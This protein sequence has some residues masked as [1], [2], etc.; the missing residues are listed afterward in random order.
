[1]GLATNETSIYSVDPRAAD[2]F[3]LP[4]TGTGDPHDVRAS[5]RA[6]VLVD[7]GTDQSVDIVVT[8]YGFNDSTGDGTQYKP[9]ADKTNKE[10]ITVSAGAS[11]PI[12]VA[13]GA[14]AFL[15]IEGTFGSAPSSGTL[16]AIYQTDRLGGGN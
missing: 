3:E 8:T 1:M 4:D 6:T 5:D 2:T 7:N 11:Q 9:V 13:A 15:T 12:T 14:H 16:E 10:T